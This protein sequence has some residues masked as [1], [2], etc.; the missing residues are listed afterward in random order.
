MVMELVTRLPYD[1]PYRWDG[2]AV[3]GQ[4]LWRPDEL[5]A[6]LALWLDAEDTASITLNGST[7]SQWNDKSGNNNHASQATATLQPSLSGKDIIFDG[8]DDGFN[9]T[10]QVLGEMYIYTVARG[11]GYLFA[12]SFD[13][14]VYTSTNLIY[15]SNGAGDI[16]TGNTVTGYNNTQTQITEEF[17]NNVDTA[18]T[19]LNGQNSLTGIFQPDFSISRIGRKWNAATGISSWNGA[20]NEII[21]ATD[22]ADRQ[23]LE[24][25]L[26]WKWGL[27]AN[28]PSG[29]PY[30]SAPP[31]I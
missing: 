3:G 5:G 31:T 23:K 25:Y 16:F 30:E 21:I 26:A 27:E 8:V 24:G 4:K 28:L 19:A 17:Y 29:H 7:V 2:T 13:R 18:T 1:H 14:I 10:S 11:S 12:D 6:S 9:L 22:N 20:I 15:W